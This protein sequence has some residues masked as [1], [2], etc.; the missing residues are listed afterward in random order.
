YNISSPILFRILEWR[1]QVDEVVAMFQKEV[2]ARVVAKE[3]SKVYGILS[4]LIQLFFE[5]EYL[6][7]VPPESFTPTP[8]VMSGVIR[9]KSKGNP[10]GIEDFKKFKT[11]VKATFNQRRKTMRN[12]LKSYYPKEKLEGKIFDLRPEQL[13]VQGFVELYHFLHQA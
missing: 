8:K 4:V 12:A 11:L 13:S 1:T 7:D 10:Y 9:M 3:G 2:A 5:V 6:M